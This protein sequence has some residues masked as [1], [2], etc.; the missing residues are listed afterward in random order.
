MDKSDQ[1]SDEE[2]RLELVRIMESLQ[3]YTKIALEA[4]SQ[5]G[6][7]VEPPM[8]AWLKSTEDLFAKAEASLAEEA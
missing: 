2:K 4:I 1:M 5:P 7:D 6:V 8:E 3:H